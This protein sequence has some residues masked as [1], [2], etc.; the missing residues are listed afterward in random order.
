MSGKTRK[1]AWGTAGVSLTTVALAMGVSSGAS[2]ASPVATAHS[3][4]VDATDYTLSCTSITTKIDIGTALT[5]SGSGG[6]TKVTMKL[7][8]QG[9]TAS[10]P[11][12]GGPAVSVKSAKGTLTFSLPNNSCQGFIDGGGFAGTMTMKFVTPSGAP[13]RRPLPGLSRYSGRPARGPGDGSLRRPRR[14]RIVASHHH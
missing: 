14:W 10:P 12:A 8:I 13:K 6:P 9:C 7:G 4:K 2:V 11:P 3:T 1:I 5:T